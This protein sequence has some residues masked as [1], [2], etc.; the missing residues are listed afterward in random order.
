MKLRKLRKIKN[1]SQ[2]ELGSIIGV[3]GQTILNWENGIYE[4]SIEQLIKLSD[5]FNVTIDYLVD[6][7]NTVSKADQVAEV[8]SS[9]SGKELIEFIKEKL[10]DN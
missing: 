8:L 10:K 4:P 7:P 2:A 6:R 3:T 9:L 5:Y 1:I